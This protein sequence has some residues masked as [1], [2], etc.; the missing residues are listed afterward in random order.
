MV[1]WCASKNTVRIKV[2]YVTKKQAEKNE[3]DECCQLHM[4]S[5]DDTSSEGTSIARSHPFLRRPNAVGKRIYE[6]KALNYTS[7]SV[8]T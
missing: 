4:C 1:L 8:T 5:F 6:I 7:I 3:I 2:G